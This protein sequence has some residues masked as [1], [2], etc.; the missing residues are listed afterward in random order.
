MAEET[1]HSGSRASMK[2]LI[3][4]PEC[5]GK[6]TFA[7][8]MSEKS[9]IAWQPE[10][11]RQYL[12]DNGPEYDQGDLLKIAKSHYDLVQQLEGSYILDT[13]LLNILI[14]SEYKYGQCHPWI[15]SQWRYERFD[16][17]FLL[18]P[19]LA[20]VQDGL[21]ELE[22]ERESVFDLFKRKLEIQNRQFEILD[23][24]D[25]VALDKAIAK[26]IPFLK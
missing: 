6:S 16:L 25:K 10:Y 13:Y 17:I 9:G 7:Q 2:I 8:E 3:T 15:P 18:K 24:S 20:W 22:N 23:P 4:G 19:T 1:Q 14:W 21:R 5:C 26:T 12:I 11:A